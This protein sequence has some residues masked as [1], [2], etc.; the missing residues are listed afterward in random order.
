MKVAKQSLYKQFQ[1]ILIGLVYL[2]AV[3]SPVLTYSVSSAYG[4]VTE[5]AIKMSSSALAATS[6]QYEVTFKPATTSTVK[7]VAVDFCQN[8]PIINDSCTG[9]VGTN[10]PTLT[11][12]TVTTTG[13]VNNFSALTW[14][15][16]TTNSNRTFTISNSTGVALTAGTAYI[17]TINLVTNPT[18][19]DT[20]TG[21]NQPG[22]FYSRLFTFPNDATSNYAGGYTATN[23]DTNVPTDA[24]GVALSTANQITITAKVQETLTFCVYTN[25]NCAAGGNSVNLGNTNG[26]LDPSGPYVDKNSKYDIATNAAS[27]VAIRIKGDTLKSGAF[28][29]AA[30]GATA[31]SSNPG[32]EQFGFCTWSSAGAAGLSPTSP[33]NNA[34]C[35]TVT[36]TAG[37]GS[38]G[39][40]GT[41]QFAFDSANTNTTYGQTYATKSAGN[42]STGTIAFIGNISFATEAGTYTTTLTFIATGTY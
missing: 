8:S 33:Y 26:V 14:T 37:T 41:A 9:T 19:N 36:Q 10:T 30:I 17:F 35:N 34:N 4:L 32:N 42:S 12:A 38:P 11:S 7:S 23:V 20:V 40:A 28:D 18:D 27:G 2:L 5:R 15:V 13:G 39:G 3:V 6:V 24:G 21:G 29:I 1:P 25:A 22:T 31:A 16:A